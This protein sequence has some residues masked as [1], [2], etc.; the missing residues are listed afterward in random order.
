MFFE[1]SGNIA[2]WLLELAK[3]STF[4]I[5]K[6][7]IFNAKTTFTSR[8]FF[9]KNSPLKCS[10]DT[11]KIAT[12]REHSV[13]I[14]IILRAGWVIAISCFSKCST[15]YFWQGCDYASKSKYP[16]VL[17][18]LEFWICLWFWICQSFGDTRVLIMS[19]V[20]NKPGFW[21]Y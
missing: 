7:Y 18:S 21:I 5:H 9:K 4:V 16:R 3:R 1:C 8:I 6:S 14:P 2:L 10:L 17:N 11:R 19:L 13:N 12:L 15:V 20:L